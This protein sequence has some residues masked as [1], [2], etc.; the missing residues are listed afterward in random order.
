[1]AR[2]NQ[3]FCTHCGRRSRNVKRRVAVPE[4]QVHF[5]PGKCSSRTAPLYICSCC[6]HVFDQNHSL[7]PNK[8]QLRQT[9]E[10]QSATI[11]QQATILNECHKQVDNLESQ[12]NRCAGQPANPQ[13]TVHRNN[14]LMKQAMCVIKQQRQMLDDTEL[15]Q[16]L[17]AMDN[18]V[19]GSRYCLT[20]LYGFHK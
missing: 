10:I 4:E 17:L 19:L 16:I 6:P 14:L 13:L 1:M 2:H 5:P 18:K 15:S 20:N 11:Q 8:A 7:N 3:Q 12:V 9:V